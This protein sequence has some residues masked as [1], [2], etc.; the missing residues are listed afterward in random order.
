MIAGTDVEGRPVTDDDFFLAFN[1]YWDPVTFVVPEGRT[2]TREV[3]TVDNRNRGSLVPGPRLDVPGRSLV[4][5]RASRK[6][7]AG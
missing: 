4:V 7:P 3:D 5:L 1:A 2:W 6:E